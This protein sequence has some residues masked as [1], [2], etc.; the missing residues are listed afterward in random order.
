MRLSYD[1]PTGSNHDSY[2]DVM[3]LMDEHPT[4]SNHDSD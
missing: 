3:Y 1:H 4:G 2:S